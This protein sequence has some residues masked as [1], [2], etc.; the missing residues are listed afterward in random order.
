MTATTS[1]PRRPGWMLDEAAN[2][3]RE[4]LDADH[5]GR[6]DAKEDAG[7]AD[8]VAFLQRL[9]L[10]QDATVVDLGAGTGQFT[11]A[12]AP[13]CARVVAVD[14]S[15]VMLTAL[16]DKMQHSGRTNIEVVRGGFLTYDH[17]GEPVD[18]VYTRYALHHL[19]DV[20]KAIALTRIRRL[21]RTGGAL[22]LWDV[23]YD[24]APDEAE[25][26]LE[27][28]CAT[29]GAGVVGEWSRAELEEHVRDEHSTFTWLLEPMLQRAGFTVEEAVHTPD[30]IF[31]RYLLR[32]A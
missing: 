27:A 17:P 29:G 12:V 32:A 21:L 16:R 4:N 30:G 6:Y 24:F 1:Q 8:E 10:L 14:V 9:G 13:H 28:W 31:A 22:R 15:D 7:A 19:P 5:V 3:G 25:E 23:V 18:L 2:A 11:V 20:W 26:R